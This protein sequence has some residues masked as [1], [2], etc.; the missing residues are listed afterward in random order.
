MKVF[1]IIKTKIKSFFHLSTIDVK[2]AIKSAFQ[3][4]FGEKDVELIVNGLAK[5]LTPELQSTL[6]LSL[7]KY[8]SQEIKQTQDKLLNLRQDRHNLMAAILEANNEV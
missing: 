2:E 3:N 8:R 7:I 1:K 4:D 6:V 5:E